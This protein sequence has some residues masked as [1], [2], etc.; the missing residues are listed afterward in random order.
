[1]SRGAN[2]S[3]TTVPAGRV[4]ASAVE[5]LVPSAD[6]SCR[7]VTLDD[8]AVELESSA[9]FVTA[10]PLD[11]KT[12]TFQSRMTGGRTVTAKTTVA[13]TSTRIL[14]TSATIV[15]PV[16]LWML[17]SFCPVVPARPGMRNVD[18]LPA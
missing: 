15:D 16:A 8:D 3:L 9:T 7:T 4:A 11:G 2:S 5:E 12:V 14:W 18:A 10:V 17:N 6:A 1:M 13:T